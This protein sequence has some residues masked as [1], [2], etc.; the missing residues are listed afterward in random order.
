MSETLKN[1]PDD[2]QPRISL[3]LL[4]DIKGGVDRGTAKIIGYSNSVKDTYWVIVEMDERYFIFLDDVS[5]WGWEV[6]K[7]G[8]YNYNDN[9][10]E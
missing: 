4:I 1:H 9:P 5:E 10:T 8:A 2:G 7:Q 6:S 3:G